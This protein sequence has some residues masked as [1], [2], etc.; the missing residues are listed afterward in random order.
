M[1]SAPTPPVSA[2][3]TVET[4]W[5]FEKFQREVDATAS[6]Y[7]KAHPFP[8]AV[9]QDMLAVGPEIMGS[10]PGP[11]WSSWAALGDAYQLQKFSCPD[12]EKIPEPFAR[13]IHELSTPTFLKA[14]EQL[15]G[16]KNMIPDPYLKGGGLH[17]SGP[18]G[19]LA[20]HT[21][22]H[23]YEPLG[24]YRRV[25]VLVYLNEEWSEEYGGC[26][27]LGDVGSTSK[28]VVVPTWGTVVV[29]TTND[30]S[31]HGFPRPIAEDRWRRSIALYYYTTEESKEFQGDT[32]T[33]WRAH[34]KQTGVVRKVRL[35]LYRV[36]NNISRAI[37][38]LAHL[39]NP[40][41]GMSWWK[42]RQARVA[43]EVEGHQH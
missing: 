33:Y 37:S 36:L 19:V 1:S 28:T 23:V 18:G 32:A 20:P 38:L 17:L 7:T 12:I 42:S 26:L 22:F 2:P 27:E 34:G 40:N 16:I 4:I 6:K 29:F 25:N 11:D 31:V 5:D 21:D 39:A 10:F 9:F 24:L 41:Q 30:K 15:T 14:L 43:K 3:A 13:L 35:G 8:H